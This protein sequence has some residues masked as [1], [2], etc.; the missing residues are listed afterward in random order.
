MR[1]K[2]IENLAKELLNRDQKVVIFETFFYLL[3]ISVA[4]VGNSCVLLAVYRNSRLR[5][6]PNYFIVSL[7]ISD[8]LLPLLCAPYSIAVAIVGYWPFNDSVCQNLK[9]PEIS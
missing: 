3:T 8:I 6:I 1:L 9:S 5:T 2:G 7:A 4:V